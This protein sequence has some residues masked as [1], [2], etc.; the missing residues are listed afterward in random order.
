MQF[1]KEIIFCMSVLIYNHPIYWK[2][3][4]HLPYEWIIRQKKIIKGIWIWWHSLGV[5]LFPK[6][7]GDPLPSGYTQLD[8]NREKLCSLH[9]I[10]QMTYDPGGFYKFPWVIVQ[11][12]CWL[13]LKEDEENRLVIQGAIQSL[14][15]LSCAKLS[16]CQNDKQQCI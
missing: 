2:C 6:I 12:M 15:S 7:H 3:F 5:G 4:C 9:F 14:Y 1:K 10:Y 11:G 8:Y 16:I 13:A